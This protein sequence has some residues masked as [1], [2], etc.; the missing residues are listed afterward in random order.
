LIY[1][2]AGIGFSIVCMMVRIFC[3][4]LVLEADLLSNSDR[5]AL[6]LSF[7]TILGVY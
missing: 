2:G 4:L 1:C 7:M 6:L 3:F 5:K